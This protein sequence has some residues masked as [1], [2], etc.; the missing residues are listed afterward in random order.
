MIYIGYGVYMK[1]KKTK[2]TI[3]FMLVLLC[4]AAAG[5]F[6]LNANGTVTVYV[7]NSGQ[8]YHNEDCSSLRKSKIAI[9]L[10]DAV[11]SGYAVCNICNPPVLTANR[12][13]PP[14]EAARVQSA[15]LYRVNVAE[16]KT[17]ARADPGRMLRAEVV[18]HV[19][20]DTVRVRIANPPEGLR[21]VET[22]RMLGVDTPETVHPSRP[23]EA[24]GKEA[25]DFTNARL[26]GKSVYLAFDWDLRDRYGRLLVYIYLGDAASL[27]CH[28]AELIR[29]GYAHAYTRF[30]FQFVEEFRALEQ[31]AR[32]EQRG[33]WASAGER[34]P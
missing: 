24:F 33:L 6:F 21:A 12:T 1:T 30:A 32:R 8:K 15:A 7:T 17:T 9:P 23:V 14:E 3:S 25:S 22:V 16:L 26:H 27:L 19:D 18:D 2:L 4:I 11:R 28:N 20:G 5:F 31:E 13:A 29:S 10:E 34:T